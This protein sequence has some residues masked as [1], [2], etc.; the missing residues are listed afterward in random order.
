VLPKRED[1]PRPNLVDPAP[2]IF[3]GRS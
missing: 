1:A 3:D 2:S